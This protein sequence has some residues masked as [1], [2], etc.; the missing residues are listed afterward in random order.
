MKRIFSI[1]I[2]LSLFSSMAFAA[3]YKTLWEY[4]L[5]KGI[6]DWEYLVKDDKVYLTTHENAPN[7]TINHVTAI[8]SDG[9]LAWNK[10]IDYDL[11]GVFLSGLTIH[12][13]DIYVHGEDR[14]VKLDLN[15]KTQWYSS[16]IGYL[17]EL[18]TIV[19]KNN[20]VYV[21][22]D[23]DLVAIDDK[24]ESLWTAF[25]DMNHINGFAL[26]PVTG[27]IITSNEGDIIHSVNANGKVDWRLWGLFGKRLSKPS[28]AKDGTLYVRSYSPE[29]LYAIDAV[30]TDGELPY[31]RVKWKNT[32][33]SLDYTHPGHNHQAISQGLI[34][35]DDYEGS[36]ATETKHYVLCLD[37]NDK[38]LWKSE[39]FIADLIQEPIVS[40]D[41]KSYY[42]SEYNYPEEKYHLEVLDKNGKLIA[43]LDN[44]DAIHMNVNKDGSIYLLSRD[45]KTLRVIKLT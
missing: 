1:I 37:A 30:A 34:Y 20:H 26:S 45:K 40:D 35:L 32:D 21:I 5:E 15:G 43:S 16:Y 11:A 9:T 41:G 2:L 44:L 39:I 25:L 4:H 6:F 42:L 18:P 29:I 31:G 17:S 33:L 7:K 10:L 27:N 14:V 28:I 13:N 8:N 3:N 22:R 12:G 36:Y 24:G 23:Q 19:D 38:T